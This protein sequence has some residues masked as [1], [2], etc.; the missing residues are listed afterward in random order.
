ML[1]ENATGIEATL[2]MTRAIKYI[3]FGLTICLF[4]YVNGQTS[5]KD[6]LSA[7]LK[8]NIEDTNKVNTLNALA[9]EMKYIKPDTSV[10]LSTLALQL[11]EKINWQLGIGK[12]HHR[13]GTF[14]QLKGDYARSIEEYTKTIAL[15]DELEKS[16]S[17]SQAQVLSLKS[18]AIG[19]I[20]ISYSIQGDYPKALDAYFKALKIAEEL[21]D[22]NSVPI[23][24]GNIGN[25][26]KE[27]NDYSKALDYYFKALKKA[28]EAGDKN[29]MATNL[30]NIGIVY[31][32]QGDYPKALDYYFRALKLAEELENKN[33]MA[34]KL[35]NIGS[36]YKEQKDFAKA[37]DYYSRALKLSEELG[38]KD[39][40][41]ES[42]G[43]I[44][45]LYFKSG[46]FKEAEE[47]LTK[48][49]TLSESLGAKN[50]LRQ[51]E[52]ALSQLYDTTGRQKLA[53]VHFRK[54]T[55][56][57]DTLFSEEKARQITRKEMNYEFEKKEAALRAEQ[58]KKDAIATQKIQK[59]NIIRNFFVGGFVVMLL[60]AG[61]FLMQ[62]NRISK[63]KKRS[64]EL[65][66]NILPSE[67]ADEL[68]QTGHCQAKTYSMVTVMFIDFKDFTSVSEKIS[69]EL[70]VAEIDY[71]F[72]AFDNII[73]KYKIEKIKTI[74]DAYIC[75]GGLPVLNFTHAEDIISAGMAIKDFM[76]D[77]KKEKENKMEI[78]FEIRI[79]IHTGPVV[80]GI[81]GVKKFAYDIWGDT[82]NLAARIESS[83]E[84][85]K[86]NISGTTYELVKEKFIFTHRG[87]IEA[88]HKGMIDMYF[89]ERS[90]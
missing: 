27:Q 72:S 22:K 43:N 42:R 10:L 58:D 30:G 83:G 13:L 62:R 21:G 66:L 86:V 36:V 19:S 79:G 12:S 16:G 59:Q 5:K 46:K 3:L 63:E 9:W 28:E 44:G 25:V 33:G 90:V 45:I 41:A 7:L 20:A 68:K 54:A 71:C 35:I 14:Y 89:V 6:S 87:K 31:S 11:A 70:L 64:E 47:Q 48:A 81:V 49:I 76:L 18:K 1:I 40:I 88:K 53:L 2:Q 78:P 55:M 75:A 24:L 60:F 67:V 17:V 34:I 51:F 85:G 4:H 37:L 50:Y 32:E 84:A 8:L 80:A 82:V 73:Q 61:I 77:R 15:C 38:T 26:Y 57:K 74:G 65:L 39:V 29:A 23:F 52:E 56:L 69:G